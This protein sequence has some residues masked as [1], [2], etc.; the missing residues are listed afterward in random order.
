M[1]KP[2]YHLSGRAGLPPAAEPKKP[3]SA[4]KAKPDPNRAT[5]APRPALPYTHSR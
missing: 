3:R 5:R 1:K 4:G 2:D